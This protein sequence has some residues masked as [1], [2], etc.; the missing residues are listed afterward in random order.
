VRERRGRRERGGGRRG[1][2]DPPRLQRP[3]R[4]SC[5][6][7][8]QVSEEAVSLRHALDRVAARSRRADAAAAARAD[9]LAG[10]A[11]AS[12]W[13][14][15][16]DAEAGAIVSVRSSRRMLEE[17]LAT[18]AAA[19][20]EMAG[21]RDRLK[22]AR[23][24]ALDVLHGLGASDAVL[25]LVERR[26]RGDAALAYLGMAVVSVVLLVAWWRFKR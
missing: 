25:R 18:G 12:A 10:A 16:A 5:S 3:P 24:K 7:V 1:P 20:V 21:Q 14:A 2:P 13:A 4:P 22:A 6:K 17:T 9:L 23:R 15:N 8:E 11:D 26:Q 19:L